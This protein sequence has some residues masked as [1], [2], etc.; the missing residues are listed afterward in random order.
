MVYGIKSVYIPIHQKL[1]VSSI[2]LSKKTME[3]IIKK[4]SPNIVHIQ[5]SFMISKGVAK[6][7]KKSG[8]PIIGT[9]HFMAENLVQYFHMPK[10]I[11]SW[12]NKL[13]WK[14]CIKVFEQVNL[15][16]T[17]TKTAAELLKKEGFS[18][19]VIAV[20][21]GIDLNRFKPTNDGSYLKQKYAIPTDRPV[22]L[23]AGRLDKEKKVEVI[24]QALSFILSVTNV[25]LVLAGVGN[26]KQIL[27]K[28]AE[29]L[30]IQQAVTFTGFV[31]E[32]DWQNIYRIADIFVIASIAELQSIVT[33]E[34]MASGLPVVATN[35][36]AL[37]EL[38]HD[39][40]NGY[41]FSDGDSETLAKEVLKILSNKNLQTQMSKKSLEIIQVHDINKTVDKYESLYK[42]VIINRYKS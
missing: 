24:L 27:R 39:G 20:S 7:A 16:T 4:I 33:M 10:I 8:I 28:L 14:Q 5:N 34:A 1:R 26:K 31:S 30:N 15:V 17:P 35:V 19:D 12:L 38:V 6:I 32:K 40:G 36:M 29:K 3:K 42:E 18:K 41:L 23:Y 22:L 11:E 25:H 37:P 13:S 9:N 2:T 21:N